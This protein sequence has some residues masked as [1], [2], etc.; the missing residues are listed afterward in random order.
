MITLEQKLAILN[1][2]INRLENSPKNIKCPGVLKK[3]Y[4]E[5]RNLEKEI[6]T[7]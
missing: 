2:K 4:R 1:D 6:K 7:V 5:R 3:L